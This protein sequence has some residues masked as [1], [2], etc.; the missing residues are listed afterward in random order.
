MHFFPSCCIPYV[1]FHSNIHEAS[2]EV[3]D[4]TTAARSEPPVN[5]ARGRRQSLGCVLYV[6]QQYRV[7]KGLAEEMNNTHVYMV[8]FTVG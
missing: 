5:F 3:S 8:A 6:M 4:P 2:H 7:N 1:C